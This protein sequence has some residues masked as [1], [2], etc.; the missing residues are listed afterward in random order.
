MP[1]IAFLR[2]LATLSGPQRPLHFADPLQLIPK[3][4]TAIAG[5]KIDKALVNFMLAGSIAKL[6]KFAL[7]DN[8][9]MAPGNLKG[10]EESRL[11]GQISSRFL[12]HVGLVLLIS[13]VAT[14]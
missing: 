14:E 1:S 9:E 2:L 13:K 11:Y 4:L 7:E 5:R 6:K 3:A 12:C 8:C 10:R